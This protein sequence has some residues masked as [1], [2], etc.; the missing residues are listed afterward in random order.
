MARG[1]RLLLLLVWGMALAGCDALPG[2]GPSALDIAGPP[3]QVASITDGVIVAPL[4]PDLVA[5]LGAQPTGGLTG[6]LGAGHPRAQ[7]L[8][9][10]DLLQVTIWE[11][12]G[13]GLFVGAEARQAQL[14]M[15][16]DQAGEVFVPYAG[17]LAAAGLSPDAL[18]A[19]IASALAGRALDPQV[20]VRLVARAGGTISVLG[21]VGAPGRFSVPDAGL[22]VTDALAQAGGARAPA[23]DSRITVARGAHRGVARLDHLLQRPASD[24]WLRPGDVI[25]VSAEPRSFTAFGAVG[26]QGDYPITREVLT[27]AQAIAQAGGLHDGLADA[28]GVFLFRREPAARLRAAAGALPAHVAGAVPAGA[29]AVPTILRLD[30]TDPRAFF[31]ADTMQI[32]DGDMLYV[33]NAP[34]SEFRK[35]MALVLGPALA[36]ARTAQA[37]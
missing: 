17:K 20:Q 31:L 6:A 23:Y 24:I 37:L 21:A 34:A 12:Q 15:T 28:G 19:K 7:G 10:G 4:T 3:E 8:A 30:F 9:A 16:V 13:E 2:R 25:S 35:F 1:I 27:L 5:R 26:R 14:D 33:A 22:R 29:G 32:A 36:N 11:P 18:R